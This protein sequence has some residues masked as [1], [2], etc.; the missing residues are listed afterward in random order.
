MADK[1]D[2]NKKNAPKNDPA[3]EKQ[4]A[5]QA[6]EPVNRLE[7]VVPVFI[8]KEMK[9]SY[10]DYSMSVI[11]GRALPDVRDGL[12]PVHRRI[13]F[14][15]YDMGLQYNKPFKKCAR[16]VG[17]TMG[18][19]HPHGDLAIYDALVRMAQDFNL[20]YTLVKGQGNFGA[21]DF[22]AAASRYTECKLNKIAEAILADI[23]KDTVDF[24]PNFDGSLKEPT[25]LPSKIPNLLINGSAGIAVGMA[26]NIP[27]H[28]IS[29]V[30]DA[31]IALV[32]NLNITDYD[33]MK[34][35][36]GPDF[37]TGAQ[38]IGSSGIKQA[39]KTGKG[40]I[41][42]R[43]KCSVEKNSIIINEIP[44]QVDKSALIEEIAELVGDK[45]I[46]GISDIRDESD[47]SGTRILI[48]IKKA[49]DPNIVLNQ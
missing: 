3:K 27:P 29:E 20:R 7:K 15:M 45:T 33:L 37:P 21:T 14:A 13:L 18:K 49:F 16:V 5:A 11:V 10:L 30:C 6:V 9:D 32:S 4:A 47:K 34:Y 17:D 36:K 41:T 26:T 24:V 31:M 1:K 2:K 25:L 46:E 35:V 44:Y 8:E 22:A 38:I 43:A 39:Y 12:K 40:K 23:D 19:L 48:E 28:N 42:V